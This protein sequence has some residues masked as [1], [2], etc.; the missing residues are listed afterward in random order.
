MDL[1]LVFFVF[2]TSMVM[3]IIKGFSMIPALFLGLVGF[4]LVAMRRGFSFSELVKMC[5][6]SNKNSLVVIK[7]MLTI[8]F[9]TAVWRVSGTIS[10]FVYYGIKI[11]TPSLFL[12]ITFVLCCLLSYALGTSFGV[13]GTVG[14]IFMTLA[15][16]GNVDPL[17]AGGVI[18]SGVYFG[19]RCSPVSS[20]ANMVAG[21]TDTEIYDNVKLMMKTGLPAL[22]ITLAI[23]TLISFQNPISSV[24]EELVRAFERE[25]SLS[26]WAFVPAI[27][28]LVLPLFKV[29]VIRSMM[30][31][32]VSG[33]AVACL[34]QKVALYEV[35]KICIF[36]Y[37]ASGSGLAS[38]LNGGGLVS[39]LQIVG[40]LLI[41]SSYSGIFSGTQ[42]LKQIQD[43]LN[44]ACTRMGRFG[45]MVI[46]SILMTSIFCNQ[47]IATLMTCDLMKKPYFDLGADKQELMI[48]LENSVILIGCIIPWSIGCTVPLS[49]L[50]VSISAM[51]YAIYMYL[52]PLTYFF[53]K[54][55]YSKR[56][57]REER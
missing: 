39:M 56:I 46:T 49:F 23:Y 22:L 21:I 48:D 17:I 9:I 24:D 14:V 50:G 44:K 1:Y 32:I 13:A 12:L 40:I 3:T 18:M 53:L 31:S 47:T 42:M 54:A 26:L 38:I 41:S 11:I 51:P 30:I 34:V 19:D 8:G 16:S 2:M 43:N 6:D 35:I 52:V 45:V 7:V 27:F 55:Q 5:V 4:I 10:I 36:G 15:R 33:I 20:S 57:F 25:F 29:K 28:M 37:R